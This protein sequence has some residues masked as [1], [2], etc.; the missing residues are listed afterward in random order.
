M[1]MVPSDWGLSDWNTIRGRTRIRQALV[2]V[3]LARGIPILYYGTEQ[4]LDGHQG[5]ENSKGQDNLRESMW[6]TG[7]AQQR[8]TSLL[9]KM[10]V[11]S[12]GYLEKLM[13]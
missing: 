13:K 6:Q 2:W 7:R 10:L 5:P 12:P 3:F 4:G 8:G 11:H 9:E 1:K